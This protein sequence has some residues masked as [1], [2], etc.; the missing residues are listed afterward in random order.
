MITKN[1]SKNFGYTIAIMVILN[2][3]SLGAEAAITTLTLDDGSFHVKARSQENKTYTQR[4]AVPDN[5]VDWNVPYPGYT[6]VNFTSGSVLANAFNLPKP[7][8]AQW[9]DGINPTNINRKYA[10]RPFSQYY[11]VETYDRDNNGIQYP[12]NPFGRTGMIG[13]GLLGQWGGNNAADPLVARI[14]PITGD[15]EMLLITRA[16]TGAIAI[17]GGIVDPGEKVSITAQRELKEETGIDY[18]FD[19]AI[20]IYEGY[21][22]DPRNTDNAWMETAAFYDM[23][24][25]SLTTGIKPTAGDDAT[26]AGF[27]VISDELV[28][29]LYASHSLFVRKALQVQTIFEGPRRIAAMSNAA[30][31]FGEINH[32]NLMTYTDNAY[33]NI[34]SNSEGLT[35]IVNFN[36]GNL[37]ANG[38]SSKNSLGLKLNNN[39]MKVDLGV[40]YVFSDNLAVGGMIHL[41]KLDGKFGLPKADLLSQAGK[42]QI[43]EIGA[44]IFG[45][46]G[47]MECGFMHIIGGMSKL[48]YEVKRNVKFTSNSLKFKGKADGYR[49][50][51]G[52]ITGMNITVSEINIEQSVGLSY[53]RVT[54]SNYHE[55]H[56]FNDNVSMSMNRNSLKARIGTK[57]S[58]EFEIDNDKILI[59]Y[60]K[61]SYA[62]ELMA[63]P[64]Y[65]KGLVTSKK[66]A[67]QY[68][69]APLQKKGLVLLELGTGYSFSK[70]TDI[71]LST[72][73]SLGSKYNNL[74][75]IGLKVNMKF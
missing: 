53:N 74:K 55:N 5:Q 22:D 61:T 46:T 42:S 38:S 37:K 50:H 20:K 8:S 40:E 52:I 66:I 44:N 45:T 13:R 6:P 36:Y 21:V 72:Q 58:K 34:K 31:N 30:A 23:I 1:R 11:K 17:P 24:P 16:D 54:L 49:Y 48:N 15:F 41:G 70:F 68:D 25:E 67:K 59:P 7:P 3:L 19:N 35:P 39:F 56:R 10:G 65:V 51:A 33:R 63:Q 64:K 14:N 4:F 57:V 27:K 62:H 18:S 9:A 26:T 73:T 32:Q 12:K 2:T 60:F 75:Q 43:T 28:D 69:V 47:L 71:S 29:R